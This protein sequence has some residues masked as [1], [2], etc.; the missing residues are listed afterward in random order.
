MNL[1]LVKLS[2][3]YRPQLVEMMDEWTAAGEKIIPWAITKSDYRDFGT[4]LANLELTEPRDGKVPDSTWFCLDRDTNRF[5]GAVNI[6][7]DLN[8][9][10]LRDGG[11]IGDGVRPSMRRR[12]IATGMIRLALEKCRELGIGRVLMVCDAYNT[13]SARSIEKNGGVLE[14]EVVIDGKAVRRYWITI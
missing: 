8:E 6:R 9:A 14:N 5:V 1:C 13:G 4:Y 10:L 2:E 11:H 12:G 7:H 3:D